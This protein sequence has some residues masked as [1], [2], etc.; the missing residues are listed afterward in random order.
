MHFIVLRIILM[1]NL[2]T[3]TVCSG[4]PRSQLQT[5][6]RWV[7]FS[8]TRSAVCGG[9]HTSL[10]A[11]QGFVDISGEGAASLGENSRCWAARTD[12]LCTGVVHFSHGCTT[13]VPPSLLMLLLFLWA[14]EMPCKRIVQKERTTTNPNSWLNKA[15]Y[16]DMQTWCPSHEMGFKV[17]LQVVNGT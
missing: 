12:F 4:I 10:E 7:T 8:W 17:S 11:P 2:K 15:A 14:E 5:P 1:G 6:G 3:I 13:V 9:H 16:C